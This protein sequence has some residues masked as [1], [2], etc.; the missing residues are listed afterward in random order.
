M[1]SYLK[2]EKQ[3]YAPV[4]EQEILDED[5]PITVFLGGL[6]HL[7]QVGLGAGLAK[8][9]LDLVPKEQGRVYVAFRAAPPDIAATAADMYA[10][11]NTHTLSKEAFSFVERIL[12]P[13]S[14]TTGAANIAALAEHLGRI[15]II[16]YSYGTS[17]I[18][19][20]EIIL[21][22]KIKA[23]GATRSQAQ[24]IMNSVGAVS[25]GPVAQPTLLD[26]YGRIKRYA[27]EEK[28]GRS[29]FS[30]YIACRA[31]DKITQDVLGRKLE[32]KTEIKEKCMGAVVQDGTVLVVDDSG[33]EWLRQ[34]GFDQLSS[35]MKFPKLKYHFDS[36]GHDLRLYTNR[37][38]IDGLVATYPSL[39]TSTITCDA[40]KE[41]VLESRD[42]S[43]GAA[44]RQFHHAAAQKIASPENV[45]AA[46]QR[47][48]NLH[49]AF[50]QVVEN[51]R[52]AH[53]KEA[54]PIIE[55]HLSDVYQMIG[56]D[57]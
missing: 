18:Q 10:F 2:L 50:N 39:S 30:Q 55:A 5:G 16:G 4:T 7:N 23:L 15:N 37:L 34:I 46:C 6:L 41:M 27:P 31:T 28:R 52:K 24:T 56:C 21:F 12:L 32:M 17:L 26:R 22:E 43:S 25:M 40:V 38:S 14:V 44:K 42:V 36:E 20:S 51:Y 19:Q 3:I 53:L 13:S 8:I 47:I 11:A 57:L 29:L 45:T 33:D 1:L 9:L 48:I 35:G 54:A 49:S